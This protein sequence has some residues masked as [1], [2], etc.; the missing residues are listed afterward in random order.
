MTRWLAILP[1]ALSLVG[2]GGLAADVTVTFLG[3]SC[4]T[5]QEQG[6]PVIMIDPYGTYVPYPGLPARADIVLMT[7][8]HIDHCPDC[9]GQND[10]VE[11]NPVKVYLLDKNGRCSEKIPPAALRVTDT[12]A[13]SVIEGSHVTA[14]G[15]GQGNV[16]LFVFDVAGIRFAHLGDL[17][18]TLTSAQVSALRDVDVLFVPVGGAFTLDAAEAMTVLGQLPSVKVAFPMHYAVAGVTPWQEMAPVSRFTTLASGTKT[19]RHVGS[20][21]VVLS[22]DTLPSVAEIWVLDYKR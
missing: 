18:R 6:G 12:F 9:Y 15:G 20:P 22:P 19:V 2:V 10:R 11:G 1:L 8:G 14:S 7:H 13:T 17:G 3:H 5:I 16:C 21:S 4:F